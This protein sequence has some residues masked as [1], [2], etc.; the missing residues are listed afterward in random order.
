[1]HGGTKATI[2]TE[3]PPAS[4]N[5]DPANAPNI[6]RALGISVE[7]IVESRYGRSIGYFWATKDDSKM[8]HV[9]A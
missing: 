9:A 3:F 5:Y 6:K 1:M 7:K 2:N 4:G 8:S